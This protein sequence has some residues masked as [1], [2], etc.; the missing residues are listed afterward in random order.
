M[1][2][3]E[4]PLW[5]VDTVNA[6]FGPMVAGL[7]GLLGFDLDVTSGEH[8]I[9]NYLVIATLIVLA[10]TVG[11]ALMRSRLS[12]EDPGPVQLLLEDG[13]TALYGLLED[14]IG[15][16]G[17][18][19]ATLIGSVGLFILLSNL[20]GLV[21]GLMAPT[22]NI[23][24]TLGC[25]ITVWVYYHFQGFKEQGVVA[26]IKHF[27]APPGAPIWIA[28]IYFPIE[29]ISHFSRVLSLSVRLFGNVFGEELVILI[30]FSIVPFLVPLPMMMLGIITGSLQAF[31]F[32]MLTMIYLQ[33]A[34][35]VDHEHDDAHDDGHAHGEEGH[36][37][38]AAA[39]AA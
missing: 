21:P 10:V 25:A 33:G 9:P 24:V 30:L 27:A 15:P 17:P 6:V 2:Q 18:R 37:G 8:V 4:H 13:L 3:L 35:T 20:A 28:P 38:Q 14:T 23:N 39:V 22:S 19:Y 26:Y 16:K 34:V 29:I 32:V 36:D 7:L 12:V 11:C 5:I 31:I 1:E